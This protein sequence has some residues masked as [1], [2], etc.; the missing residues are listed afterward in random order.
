MPYT[1]LLPEGFFTIP[2][3]I[4][5]D[6]RFKPAENSDVVNKICA[7]ES[8]TTE[9]I[10]YTDHQN[11]RLAGI[12]PP[13][14][15]IALF[16][17]WETTNDLSINKIAFEQLSSDAIKRNRVT[18]IG[19]INFNTF[20]HYR[21][22]ISGEPVWNMFDSEPVNPDYYPDILQQ[23]GY[24]I[25]TSFESRLIG[26]TNIPNVF[27]NKQFLLDEVQRIPFD[28]I[29]LNENSWLEYEDDLYELIHA[30]FSGNPFYKTISKEEFQ[31]LYNT[32]F[33]RRLCPYSSVLFKHQSSGRLA[34]ISL[35]L[36]DYHS[37]D[38]P[39]SVKPV[40]NDHFHRL[41]KKVLLAKSVGVH[42]D[43]RKQQLMNFLG[44][45]GM[46][47]FREMYDEVIFCTMRSDNYSLH[48]TRGLSYIKAEY[49]LFQK[50]LMF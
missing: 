22:R 19:P 35:C 45:Y 50:Q 3:K 21:L 30:V 8:L 46:L 26:K 42:P 37:L 23:L 41:D 11:I 5:Q 20:H 47:S 40:F 43:F 7:Y 27:I 31:L 4:Y 49:A 44:A 29:P 38:L 12:F 16:G 10:F 32:D 6:L 13:N 25:S 34:A 1:G 9:L 17:F 39:Q 14:T 24:S 28:F 33:A 15:N 36:P 2:E 48:F 18:I